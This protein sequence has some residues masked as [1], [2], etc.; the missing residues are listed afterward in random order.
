LRHTYLVFDADNSRLAMAKA[1]VDPGNGPVTAIKHK[2]GL[3]IIPIPAGTGTFPGAVSVDPVPVPP[4]SSSSQSTSSSTSNSGTDA[5][6]SLHSTLSMS[7]PP[8]SMSGS[9]TGHLKSFKSPVPSSPVS[10][11]SKSRKT[12]PHPSSRSG[13]HNEGVSIDIKLNET[14]YVDSP[15]YGAAGYGWWSCAKPDASIEPQKN[16]SDEYD[17]GTCIVDIAVMEYVYL[18]GETKSTTTV[19]LTTYVLRVVC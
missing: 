17:P 12:F 14:I 16:D 6:T 1:A 13:A 5:A 10:H 18:I 3:G 7:I 4:S 11:P 8:Y 19:C 2:R 15:E 9:S